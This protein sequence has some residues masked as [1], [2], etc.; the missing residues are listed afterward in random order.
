MTFGSAGVGTAPH[1]YPELL[2]TT[3]GIKMRHIPY[4][5]NA[6]AL[7]DL[8]SGQIT[9]CIMD[10]ASSIQLVR[11][12]KLKA[13]GVTSGT[14][15]PDLPDVPSIGE[16]V[17]GYE[18]VGWQGLMLRSG[19]PKDITG[20]LYRAVDNMLHRP[21]TPEKFRQMGFGMKFS[22]PDDS[23]CVREAAIAVAEEGRDRRRHRAG[24]R[25]TGGSSPISRGRTEQDMR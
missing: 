25:K 11:D 24:V 22:T 3:A 19:T 18:I 1:L 17:P 7:V 14:R 16:A 15:D 23:Q 12:G 13:L 6:P 20:K 10:I 21:D 9:M 4:R 2:D 8:M 5:G